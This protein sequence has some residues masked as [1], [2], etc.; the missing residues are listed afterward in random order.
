MMQR[1]KYARKNQAAFEQQVSKINGS[2][3]N[4]V[5]VW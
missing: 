4:P 2:L 5:G 3:I 1:E